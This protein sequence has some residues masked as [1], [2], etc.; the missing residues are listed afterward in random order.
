MA[1]GLDHP[2]LSPFPM[3]PNLPCKKY[4]KMYYKLNCMRRTVKFNYG[5]TAQFSVRGDFQIQRPPMAWSQ[6]Y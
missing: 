1:L 2:S 3:H 5:F 6:V 4:F